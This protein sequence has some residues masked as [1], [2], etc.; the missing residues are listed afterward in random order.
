M[1]TNVTDAI[2][3]F[4]A[5]DADGD[6]LTYSLGGNDADDFTISDTG[7]LS[8][9]A[10]PDFENP[11]DAD[12]DNVYDVTITADD[13]KA[14]AVSQ[15]V[16]VTVQNVDET[17]AS[18]TLTA[19]AADENADGAI[20]ADIVVVDPSTVFAVGDLVISD[21]R[22]EAVAGAGD[23]LF[24]L[25]LITGE[26][27]DFEAGLPPSLTVTAGLVVSRRVHAGGQ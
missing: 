5:T 11:T 26:E 24:V 22:F 4:A 2:G 13:G 1:S 23:N 8:F 21:P 25:K 15:D 18:V 14:P 27:F 3:T 10:A 9:A 6:T 16:A 12:T 19:I 7:E 20:V 17:P